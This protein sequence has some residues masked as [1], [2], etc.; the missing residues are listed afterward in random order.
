MS[1]SVKLSMIGTDMYFTNDVI[2]QEFEGTR[3]R[4]RGDTNLTLVLHP[5]HTVLW[6]V[7]PKE[8]MELKRA[9]PGKWASNK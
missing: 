4:L 6:I 1:H 8:R 5:L 9:K 3:T 7:H 2:T